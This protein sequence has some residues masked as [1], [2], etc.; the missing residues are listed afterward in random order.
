MQKLTQARILAGWFYIF[1]FLTLS[2]MAKAM[3]DI[4][5]WWRITQ[6][7]FNFNK[8]ENISVPGAVSCKSV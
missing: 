5:F 3:Y 4:V 2:L 8:S 7:N 6:K 1:L